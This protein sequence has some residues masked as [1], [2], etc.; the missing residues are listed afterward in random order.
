MARG[1]ILKYS[2]IER[3]IFLAFDDIKHVVSKI[4]AHDVCVKS[5]T[6][7][8]FAYVVVKFSPRIKSRKVNLLKVKHFSFC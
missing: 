6:L 1:L 2:Q 7:D 8:S 5:L 4:E 3:K